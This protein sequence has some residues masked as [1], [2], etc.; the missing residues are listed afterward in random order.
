[1]INRILQLGPLT[2]DPSSSCISS[3]C[4]ELWRL[5]ASA[6]DPWTTEV[7]EMRVRTHASPESTGF[8][9]SIVE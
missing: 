3:Q 4:G 8:A 1:V 6:T 5:E 7:R 9:A 2:P